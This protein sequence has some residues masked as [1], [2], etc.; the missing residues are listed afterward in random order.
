MPED[1]LKHIEKLEA[2]NGPVGMVGDG[3]NDAPALAR[4]S[5]GIAMGGASTDTALE[6]ADIALLGDDMSKL[7]FTYRL[8]RKTMNVIKANIVF[9]IGIK[10]IALLLVIPGWLTLWIAIF[11]DMGAT[12]IV[13]LNAIRLLYVKDEA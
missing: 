5:I 6:T 11:S 4:A 1:K 9:A 8:S 12:L 7:P 10:L 3:V 2:L 13:A